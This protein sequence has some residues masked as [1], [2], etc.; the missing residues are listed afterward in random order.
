VVALVPTPDGRGYWLVASDGGIF[1]FGGAG[2]VGS[3]PGLGV[4]VTDIVGAAP[5]AAG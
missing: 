4:N 2:D 1:G 5:T 3:L